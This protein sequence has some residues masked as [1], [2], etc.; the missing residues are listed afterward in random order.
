MYDLIIFKILFSIKYVNIVPKLKD[1]RKSQFID[2]KCRSSLHLVSIKST[3]PHFTG[4]TCLPGK[5]LEGILF[6]QPRVCSNDGRQRRRVA[7][8]PLFR[9]LMQPPRVFGRAFESSLRYRKSQSRIYPSS[10][11]NC[12]W[13]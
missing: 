3:L 9:N 2:G 10:P 1:S 4:I 13:A 7:V 8:M 6:M 12:G 11:A 5:S